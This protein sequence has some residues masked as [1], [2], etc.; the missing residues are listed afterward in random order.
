MLRCNQVRHGKLDG[1]QIAR[2][3]QSAGEQH[4]FIP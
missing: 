4:R 2:V 1:L 3:S